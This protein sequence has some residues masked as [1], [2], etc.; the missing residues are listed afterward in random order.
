[1]PNNKSAEK[2]VSVSAHKKVVNNMNKSQMNTAL[3][4]FNSAISASNIE[5][6]TSLF[7]ET[8]SLIDNCASKGII[9]SNAANHKKAQI[10]TALDQLK[11]GNVLVKVDA[12]TLKQAE[13]KAA[14]VRKKAEAEA[15]LTAKREAKEAAASAKAKEAAASKKKPAKKAEPKA[16]KAEPKTTKKTEPKTK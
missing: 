11:M 12:K 3:K 14:G 9:S 1:M 4:K 13:Q 16:E 6:A 7:G 2:R 15:S 8:S 5:L 10:T